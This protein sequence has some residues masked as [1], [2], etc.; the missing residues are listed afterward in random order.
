MNL[1]KP[2]IIFFTLILLAGCGRDENK[3]GGS[4]LIETTEVIVSAESSGRVMKM[5]FDE[6]VFVSSGDTLLKI[7]PSRLELELASAA[8][9]RRVAMANLATVRIQVKNSE[10]TREFAFSER[11]RLQGLLESGTGTQQQYDRAAYEFDNADLAYQTARANVAVLQAEIDKI[12][13]D[14]ARLERQL[15]DSYPSAPITGTVT[16]KYID[17]GELLNPGK[18]IAKIARLDTVWVKVYLSAG[19]FANIKTGQKARVDTEAGGRQYD[20][21]IS[22]TSDEAEFTPKNVQTEESRANLVYAVKVI[23][24]NTDNHLKI[25]MPVFVTLEEQ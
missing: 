21:Y 24:P 8:A 25:G 15:A 3:I 16:E 7:D 23:I 1:S 12:D 6:G 13:A 19:A 18:P 22:W 5:Y 11:D 9:A 17:P 10:R 2:I 20:G 4:G 14:I